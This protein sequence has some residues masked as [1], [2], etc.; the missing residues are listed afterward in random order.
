MRVT[1]LIE[2]LLCPQFGHA[3]AAVD[4]DGNELAA[5][6]E[7]AD[8]FSRFAFKGEVSDDKSRFVR[9]PVTLSLPDP[10]REEDA[11]EIEHREVVIFKSGS[12][13]GAEPLTPSRIG[14]SEG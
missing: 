9:F 14:S 10:A 2:V 1:Y 4:R 13:V 5:R 12:N 6:A 8:G 3:L 11:S 7:L